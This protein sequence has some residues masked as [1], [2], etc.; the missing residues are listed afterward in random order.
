MTE[1]VMTVDAVPTDT[2]IAPEHRS[3]WQQGLRGLMRNR[4]AMFGAA[5]LLVLILVAVF[6]PVL[7]PYDPLEISLYDMLQSPNWEHP[8]GTDGYG[9]D[10][11]SRVIFGTRI[12]L[13][14]GMISVAI[15]AF[16][17]SIL[18]LISGYYAGRVDKVI[19]RAMDVM[20]AFPG[21]LLAMCV[22][23][24]LGPGLTNVM[25]AVG[26]AW[27]PSYARLMRG[28]TLVA[29]ENEYVQAARCVGCSSL[30]IV[31]R[32]ILPNTIAPLI[33]L[34]TMNIG[35]AIIAGASLSFLGLGAQ[36]PQAEWGAI[37]NA[38]RRYIRIAWWVMTFPGLAILI[39]V[40]AANLLGDGLRVAL[41]PRLKR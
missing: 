5:I 15:G 8:M 19:M 16:W 9:R 11:L 30:R 41:D 38:G 6:A 40:M 32:H 12:S 31:F 35:T 34:S 23:A 29:K 10:L 20:L 21:I 39:T 25:I 26:I 2:R 22:V 17:G 28:S 4:G 18:G 33:V 37:L 36:P 13:Q 27:I 7:A 3:R 24:I 14:L 1:E